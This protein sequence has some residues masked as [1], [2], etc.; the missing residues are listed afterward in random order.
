M[1]LYD[2]SKKNNVYGKTF[3]NVNITILTRNDSDITT[4]KSI[5]R[6]KQQHCN[7]IFY[8]TNPLCKYTDHAS[9]YVCH[10]IIMN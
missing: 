2:G 3:T 5:K 6:Q 9:Y 1:C 8:Q 4:L 10:N 7:A